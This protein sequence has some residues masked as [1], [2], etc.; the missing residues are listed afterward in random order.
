[1][2]TV[3]VV[4]LFLARSFFNVCEM[5]ET[6]VPVMVYG[7]VCLKTKAR[8]LFSCFFRLVLCFFA[9]VRLVCT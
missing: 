2:P 7:V 6:S 9:T 4:I 1:M 3:S 5:S 8:C